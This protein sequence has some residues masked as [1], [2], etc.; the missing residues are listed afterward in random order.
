MG[1]C[2]SRA[3]LWFDRLETRAILLSET[4][5]FLAAYAKGLI[6]LDETLDPDT[7]VLTTWE[8]LEC[9]FVALESGG[10]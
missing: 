3:R 7:E 1:E 4:D 2:Y 9:D 5:A 6:S 10:C 8:R